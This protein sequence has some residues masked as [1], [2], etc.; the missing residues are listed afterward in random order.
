MPRPSDVNVGVAVL[1]VDNTNRV[2]MRK[3]KGAHGAGTWAF[4][5]GW[6]DKCDG[7]LQRTCVREAFEEAHL[8]IEEDDLMWHLNSTELHDDLNIRT[9]TIFMKTHLP[10]GQAPLLIEHD[11]QE[12][13]WVWIEQDNIPSPLF[14]A[15]VY[16]ALQKLWSL[17]KGS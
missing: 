9:V 11:K 15:G 16:E 5:G 14:A 17:Y 1:V 7:S 3:R 6:V 2:L 10:N 12:G 8:M 13:D 4:I